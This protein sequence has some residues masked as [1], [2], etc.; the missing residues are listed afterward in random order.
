[1]TQRLLIDHMIMKPTEPSRLRKK[2]IPLYFQVEHIIKSK[3]ITGEYSPGD[4]IPTEKLMGSTFGVSNIT[5]RQAI[6][7]LVSEG[8]LTRIQGKGTFVT[9]KIESI[10]TL[11]FN[12]SITDLIAGALKTQEVRVLD[13]V[14]TK[15][16][17]KITEVLNLGKD[18]KIVKIRRIRKNN[19]IP[20]SYVINYLPLEIGESI[21]EEDLVKYPMLYILRN[22]L[23]IPLQGG[24]QYIEAIAADHDI[25]A[26]LSVKAFSPILYM[27]TII[28]ATKQRIIEFVQTFIRPEYYRL[29][30]KLSVTRNGENEIRVRVAE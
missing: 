21:K 14:K 18:D 4:K 6:L 22:F 9:D 26:A 30:V 11:E 24:N 13:I 8:L 15:P 23:G 17:K 5:V 1:M 29:S 10:K 3:I 2:G 27:E 16:L 7:D 28:Y 19:N 20:V 25:S 12:G